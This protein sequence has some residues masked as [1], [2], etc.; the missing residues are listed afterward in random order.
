MRIFVLLTLINL[1]SCQVENDLKL[2]LFEVENSELSMDIL[3]KRDFS[4]S[5]VDAMVFEKSFN[6]TIITYEFSEDL[7]HLY[8]KSWTFT[9]QNS[10]AGSLQKFFSKNGVF[11]MIP[12]NYDLLENGS[13]ICLKRHIDNFIYFS[14][15]E[16]MNNKY[17]IQILYFYPQ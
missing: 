4:K 3:I 2:E 9:I 13:N 1:T 11:L 10:E 17:R 8:S 7:S 12:E 5:E 16:S 15:V 6:D 14:K